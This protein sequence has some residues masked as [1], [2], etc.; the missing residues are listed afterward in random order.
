VAV[1]TPEQLSE[2][3][4][5]DA[6]HPLFAAF[7]LIG[8]RGLP[9]GEACGL[10]WGD[11]DLDDGVAYI[12]RQLQE[13]A[14][15][16]LGECP[17]KTE[18]S[19]R[20]VALDAETLIILRAH[21]SRQRRH[22]GEAAV[23]SEAWVFT[24]EDGSPLAPTFLTA[25]FISLVGETNLPPV[26]LHDLRHG[27]A[28]LM[29]LAGMEL[30]TIADQLGHSSVVLTAD[31]YLSVAVELGLKSAEEAARLVLKAGSRPPNGGRR[32]RRTAPVLAE[33]TA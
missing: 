5:S 33:V 29:L 24:H 3:L 15:G 2:F 7:R 31:T 10:Q 25:M 16:R 8:M 6:A 18:S 20:A 14:S 27:A 22:L 4:A 12:S 23:A 11:L 26:R 13:D 19:R 30:K 17:L 32:R 9:R 21:C 28:T 1:W